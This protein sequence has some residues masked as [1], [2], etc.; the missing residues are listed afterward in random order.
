MHDTETF[1]L[2]TKDYTIL[3]VMLDRHLG[4]DRTM[5]AILRRKLA[6]ALVMFRDDIPAQVVTISSRV[7]YRVNGGPAETRII[8]NDDARGP[9]GMFLPIAHPRGLALL[10]LA[11]GQS[12]TFVAGDGSRETMTVE[13][14][15]YQPEAARREAVALNRDPAMD[16]P[17]P[18]GPV[19][20]VVH[21]AE[22]LP[23]KPVARTPVMSGPGFDDPGPSA[24]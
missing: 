17:R 4:R 8:A 2:T 9:V 1:Q 16:R 22:R 6:G 20:R 11:E 14:I 10:G 13:E 7:T 21:G 19:L 23:E 3:E 5:T 24:A 18:R 15:A 12:M